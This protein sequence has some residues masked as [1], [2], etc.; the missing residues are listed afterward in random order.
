MPKCRYCKKDF[1]PLKPRDA[2]CSDKCRKEAARL[3]SKA[4]NAKKAKRKW[5]I[6]CDQC[7]KEFET[8][9]TRQRFCC[10]KCKDDHNK[11]KKRIAKLKSK[12]KKK[13][14]VIM[15]D[16]SIVPYYLHRHYKRENR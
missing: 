8:R 14:D 2:H 5:T 10:T 11:E 3:R 16:G 6:K 4:Y 1:V 9:S 13:G 12:N 7:K 15:K